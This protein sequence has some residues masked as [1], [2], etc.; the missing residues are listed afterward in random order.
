MFAV[1]PAKAAIKTMLR[2][3]PGMEGV[4]VERGIPAKLPAASV[5]D[6]VYIAM[7]KGIDRDAPPDHGHEVFAIVVFV[8]VVGKRGA[9]HEATEGRLWA[10]ADAMDA[11][12]RRDPE[13][14]VA[15]DGSWFT[16]D[17]EH[18]APAPDGRFVSRAVYRLNCTK[19]M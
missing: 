19:R 16:L 9:T 13:W 12:C 17:D 11:Q 5:S 18:T 3:A 14:G 2:A 8:E 7:A 4:L 10:I 15:L 1:E 6:R